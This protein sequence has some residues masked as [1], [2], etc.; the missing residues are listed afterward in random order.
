M[1]RTRARKSTMSVEIALA[2]G[3][4]V[5]VRDDVERLTFIRRSRDFDFSIKQVR[6]LVAITQDARSS[7]MTRA[8]WPPNTSTLFGRECAS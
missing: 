7:C 4:R 5:Y 2:G 1:A 3:Q 8:I 6:A